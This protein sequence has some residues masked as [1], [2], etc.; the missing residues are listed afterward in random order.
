MISNQRNKYVIALF[1]SSLLIIGFLL[2]S[3]LLTM[4]Y[5]AITTTIT[6]DGTLGTQVTQNGSVYNI[7]GGT[8]KG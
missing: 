2:H 8:I 3:I 6:S 5:A 4:G 7:D 1:I